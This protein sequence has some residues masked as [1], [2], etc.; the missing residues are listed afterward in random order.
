MSDYL[1]GLTTF[2]SRAPL[3]L[4]ENEVMRPARRPERTCWA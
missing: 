3:R 4:H 2:F 1:Y